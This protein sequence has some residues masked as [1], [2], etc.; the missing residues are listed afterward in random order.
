MGINFF[1]KPPN[2][3][4]KR[5]FMVRNENMENGKSMMWETLLKWFDGYSASFKACDQELEDAVSLK[6]SHTKRVIVE[7]EQLCENLSLDRQRSE[8]AKIAALFHDVARFEQF[9]KYRTFSDH[10]S[11][12][13]AA[14]AVDII[15]SNR[16]LAPLDPS[17]ARKVIAAI[18]CHNEVMLPKDLAGDDRLLGQLLRDADKLDIYSIVLD[19][20][21]NPQTQ[22][23]ETVQIGIPDGNDLSP[24]VCADMLANKNISYEK[25]VTVADF[26]IIQL[27]WVYDLNFLHSFQC[28]KKR[29]YIGRI[30]QHPPS[31]PD[32]RRIVA[33]VEAYLDMKTEALIHA[34]EK[35]DLLC[36]D[37]C[38]AS[39][40][41]VA[42]LA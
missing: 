14:A 19:H 2:R 9:K 21:I 3:I 31:T 42:P 7:I 29:D 16:L 26:K 23:N 39:G 1:S 28:V 15:S 4:L 33:H 34:H 8:L 41:T 40:F 25:I 30:K 27:G 20:Y 12:N 37:E 32:V 24:E 35:G 10:R 5:P 11:I 18:R 13:H 6:Y 38:A 36:H 17:D 22:R